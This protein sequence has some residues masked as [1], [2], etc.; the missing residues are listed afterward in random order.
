MPLLGLSCLQT[1]SSAKPSLQAG[2]SQQDSPV[3]KTLVI[4]NCGPQQHDAKPIHLSTDR[5][6]PKWVW[7]TDWLLEKVFML[8]KTNSSVALPIKKMGEPKLDLRMR[9]ALWESNKANS[10]SWKWK[11]EAAEEEVCWIW[12]FILSFSLFYCQTDTV[13]AWGKQGDES[14]FS[15]QVVIGTSCRL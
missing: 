2:C 7:R 14:V 9:L 15:T 10:V 11:T 3:G 5:G 4:L 12:Q 1:I 6:D 13:C 8:Y